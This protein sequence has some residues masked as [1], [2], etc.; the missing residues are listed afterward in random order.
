MNI[1]KL[2]QTHHQQAFICPPYFFGII[3]FLD[4]T[5]TVRLSLI[6]YILLIWSLCLSPYI[7][8][9][10]NPEKND[11]VRTL[12]GLNGPDQLH[13]ELPSTLTAPGLHLS[14]GLGPVSSLNYIIGVLASGLATGW[15]SDPCP[16]YL[17][18]W[19]EP[20]D[21]C[22][23]L[24]LILIS[25]LVPFCFWLDLG[26]M[27]SSCCAWGW[28]WNWLPVPNSAR[29]AQVLGSHRWGMSLAGGIFPSRA[30]CPCCSLRD[31]N[32]LTGA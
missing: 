3:T 26:H 11:T 12:I 5:G 27:S 15:T 16:K 31:S 22:S 20:L 10:L 1:N 8:L 23:S 9:Q 13:L 18:S 30:A 19:I 7:L 2:E 4:D 28:Q 29:P 17:L 25:R 32:Y 24:I 14:P 6:R 21:V